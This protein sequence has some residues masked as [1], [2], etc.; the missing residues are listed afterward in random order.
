M[1]EATELINKNK[2]AAAEL[3][4]RMTKDKSSPEEIQKIMEASGEYNFNQTPVGDM[5]M[6]EF[7]HAIGSIKVKPSSWSDLLF[8]TPK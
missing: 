6:I 1:Q 5:R 4:I 3:Y 7:M 2:R 8:A